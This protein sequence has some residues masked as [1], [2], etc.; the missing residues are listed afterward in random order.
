LGRASENPAAAI[1]PGVEC[2]GGLVVPLH[3]VGI[4]QV[5]TLFREHYAAAIA[6]KVDGVDET[7]VAEM[8]ELSWSV[9]DQRGLPWLDDLARDV[10]HGLR[11]LPR[12]PV[13]TAVAL[14]TLA[15]GIGANT[16]SSRVLAARVAGVAI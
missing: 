4:E 13:F 14:L 16:P 8:A 1:D 9:S 2:L 5:S 12:T 10:S 11:T 7:L 3:S 15:W 6:A